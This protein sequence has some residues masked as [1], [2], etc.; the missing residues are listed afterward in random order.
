MSVFPRWRSIRTLV[1]TTL[2]YKLLLLVLFPTLLAMPA[3]LGLTIYW[4][5]SFTRDNLFLKVK[6]DLAVTRH[7]FG[8]MQQDYATAL[9][10]LTDSYSFRLLLTNGDARGLQNELKSLIDEEG[11]TF[12]HLT[13]ELGN[14]LYEES[15]GS[16][17]YTHL[18]LP[19]KRRG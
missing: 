1:R 14:W 7:A 13:D 9:Q 17:S 4:F 2:R 12:V 5:N 18:T 10:R 11:F 16:V 19:T 3:T 8:Q 6:S 15:L